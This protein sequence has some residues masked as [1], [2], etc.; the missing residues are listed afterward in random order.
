MQK[1][2]SLLARLLMLAVAASAL[3]TTSVSASALHTD[4]IWTCRSPA[5][6]DK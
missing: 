2:R 5:C 6:E 1:I 4:G 3:G